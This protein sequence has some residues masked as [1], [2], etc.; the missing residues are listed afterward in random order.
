MQQSPQ[1]T[2]QKRFH[3]AF[4]AFMTIFFSLFVLVDALFSRPFPL[5]RFIVCTF[6]GLIT[7]YQATTTGRSV[8]R[9]V[10]WIGL[11]I[12]LFAVFI[13]L[14]ILLNTYVGGTII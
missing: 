6:M 14:F 9:I 2:G 13:A 3:A 8:S 1:I 11:L 7:G 5:I 4:N 12:I 10:G